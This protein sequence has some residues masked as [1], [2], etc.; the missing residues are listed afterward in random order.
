MLK[1]YL[2]TL[3]VA[4]AVCLVASIAVSLTTQFLRSKQIANQ[5]NFKR[6]NILQSAGLYQP[7][8]APEVQ[9]EALSREYVNLSQGQIVEIENYDVSAAL[10][11]PAQHRVLAKNEDIASIRRLENIAEV[12][13]LY[14]ERG[15]TPKRVILPIRGYGLWSTLYGFIAIDVAEKSV[16]ALSFYQHA[17]TP[18]LGGNVDKP[19]WKA[20]WRGKR[21][22]DEVGD[23][24][25]K[26]VKG[27]ASEGSA[28]EV[29]G[30]S[31][32]TITTRG[33]DNLV[34]FWLG[35]EGFD[36]YLQNIFEE[37]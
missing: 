13:V 26:V 7:G 2:R 10:K 28:Y 18:G 29:D 37:A 30:L 1:L 35:P 8:I 16:Y 21:L 4:L 11:D 20:L 15:V 27:K 25:L 24:A 34:R 6:V 23:F 22:Y 12:Y 19:S 3:L 33:V 5:E 31:G 36:P 9:F 32:A 14:D 17:E